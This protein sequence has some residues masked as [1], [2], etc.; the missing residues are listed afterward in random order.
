[1]IIK[2]PPK[3]VIF[4]LRDAERTWLHSHTERGNDQGREEIQRL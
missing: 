1:M 3:A 4:R 2:E